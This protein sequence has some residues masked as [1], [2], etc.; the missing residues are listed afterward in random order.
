MKLSTRATLIF[1][2]VLIALVCLIAFTSGSVPAW[3]SGLLLM[4]TML[5]FLGG[6]VVLAIKSRKP[7]VQEQ[8]FCVNCHTVSGSQ[9]A[10]RPTWAT[11]CGLIVLPLLLWR[12]RRT[13]PACNGHNLVPNS[14][15]LAV[16]ANKQSSTVSRHVRQANSEYAAGFLHPDDDLKLMKQIT[17]LGRPQ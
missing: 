17:Q 12:K 10:R 16:S 11:V 9:Y 3:A 5:W 15:P 1:L 2:T 7:R 14:A 4:L 6:A 13:C 8:W